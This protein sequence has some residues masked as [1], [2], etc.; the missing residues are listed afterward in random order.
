[1]SSPWIKSVTASAAL[2]PP[3]GLNGLEAALNC[4]VGCLLFQPDSQQDA[5]LFNKKLFSEEVAVVLMLQISKNNLFSLRHD[6]VSSGYNEKTISRRW[7]CGRT[8][9]LFCLFVCWLC[10][11]SSQF[12]HMY[13]FTTDA[14]IPTC[15][16][17]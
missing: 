12:L 10:V 1:M 8:S 17:G 6:S 4:F 16:V 11:N 9:A 5:F 13:S 14:V 15:H 7:L 3:D 2:P